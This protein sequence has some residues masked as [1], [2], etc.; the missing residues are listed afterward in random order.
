MIKR[1]LASL[2]GILDVMSRRIS[3]RQRSPAKA[4]HVR[5]HNR[6]DQGQKAISPPKMRAERPL[7]KEKGITALPVSRHLPTSPRAA[8]KSILQAKPLKMIETL[9][10]IPT[11]YMN[12]NIETTQ[13]HPL[14]AAL[15][16]PWNASA[17]LPPWNSISGPS[18]QWKRNSG[19]TSK[20][21]KD[22]TSFISCIAQGF[23]PE[24]RVPSIA[25]A[26]SVSNLLNLAN[27]IVKSCVCDFGLL[28]TDCHQRSLR[29]RSSNSAGTSLIYFPK[30]KVA[31]RSKFNLS[32]Y[33]LLFACLASHQYSYLM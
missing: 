2:K 6:V 5:D 33:S 22:L 21:H 31:T 3:I 20:Y 19:P 28:E 32:V 8:S 10:C 16:H 23:A 7:G 17:R 4:A 15:R 14:S 27:N 30:F 12:P 25:K 29:P 24:Q 1:T 13:E 11:A 9:K 18:P 26:S